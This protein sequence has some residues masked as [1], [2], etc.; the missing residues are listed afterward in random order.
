[1]CFLDRVRRFRRWP[2]PRSTI[3]V[4]LPWLPGSAV[5]AA[6]RKLL[7]DVVVHARG[8]GFGVLLPALRDLRLGIAQVPALTIRGVLRNAPKFY[9]Q[10]HESAP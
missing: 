1:M 2:V 5:R 6:A 4:T 9:R 7:S 8:R 3:H 10:L